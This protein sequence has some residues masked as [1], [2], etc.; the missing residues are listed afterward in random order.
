ML[1]IRCYLSWLTGYP[2]VIRPVGALAQHMA[3]VPLSGPEVRLWEVQPPS[4]SLSS[5]VGGSRNTE[6]V[7][8]GPWAQPGFVRAGFG[9]RGCRQ[10][11]NQNG[12]QEE[13]IIEVRK[14]TDRD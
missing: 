9:P 12:A 7:D 8:L 1:P 13:E 2:E 4:T 11:Q 10:R 14:K 6:H 5:I 3:A